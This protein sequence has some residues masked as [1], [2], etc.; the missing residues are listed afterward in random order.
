MR[1]LS[2][3]TRTVTKN[4][5]DIDLMNRKLCCKLT[6]RM[7]SCCPFCT[8]EY[9]ISIAEFGISMLVTMGD[10]FWMKS[11]SMEYSSGSGLGMTP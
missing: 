7:C 1:Q 8:E 3:T 4:F 6:S 5:V 9:H 2:S 10:R 11:A